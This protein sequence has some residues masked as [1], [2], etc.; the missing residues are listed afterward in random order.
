MHVMVCNISSDPRKCPEKM[1]HLEQGSPN[2]R[3]G[4]KKWQFEEVGVFQGDEIC[5]V[6]HL[7]R[8]LQKWSGECT[9]KFPSFRIWISRIWYF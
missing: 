1:A 2:N 6:S 3:N 9:R 8:P 7:G 5:H 4:R